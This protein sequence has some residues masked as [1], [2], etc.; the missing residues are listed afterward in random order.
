[1]AD[2]TREADAMDARAIGDV[3]RVSKRAVTKRADKDGWLYGEE[4]VSGGMR[5]LYPVSSLP[6]EVREAVL[7]HRA[8]QAA[9]QAAPAQSEGRA[10]GRKL[11]IAD[12]VD[13]AVQQRLRERGQAAAA[14][15]TGKPRERMDA[16]LELLSRLSQFARARAIGICAAM[17]EFCDAYNSG[18]MDVPVRVRSHTGADLHPTTLRRWRR[19]VKEQGP[20]ALAGGYGNRKGSNGIESTPALRDFVLGV[21]REQPHISA[22]VMHDAIAARLPE[23]LPNRRT[24]ERFL[25]TWKRDNAELFLAVTNPDAWKNKYM[26]AF[27][28]ASE[29]I[30]RANQ[31][32]ML[33]STPADLM[34]V[35]GRHSLVGM[36]DVATRQFRLY[37]SRTSTADAV[38]QILRRGILELGV[39]EA[40]KMDNGRDY[41]SQRVAGVLAGL[42]IEARFSAPFSPWEKPHIERAFRTFS[43]DLLEILPGYGGHNV[44]EAQAIRSRTAF[45]EQLFKKNAEPKIRLTAAELQAFC[46]RWVAEVYTHTAHDGLGGMTPF[47]KAAQLRD[48]VRT[49]SDVRALDLLL[50]AGEIRTVG[51]KG[52]RLD[53]LLYIA[54]ELAEAINQPVLVRRDD[55]DIG[56]AVVYY[57][58]RFLCIAE[59]PEVTGV[60]QREVASE[61]KARKAKLLQ[62]QKAELKALGRKANV[63]GL[64]RDI[65]DSKARDNAALHA[66]PAPN[67]VHI[68]PALEAAGVAA[69]ALEQMEQGTAA[70]AS[71]DDAVKA[72][73][74][75]LVRKEQQAEDEAEARFKWALDLL[76]TPAAARNDIDAARLRN[77]TQTP[78]YETRWMFFE[79]FGA[80][81]FGLADHYNAL[82]SADALFHTKGV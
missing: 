4:R 25:A 66:F 52:L 18:A 60:S 45:S 49:V 8:L 56:R 48:L 50:G 77:Y 24:L 47:Q 26:P 7:R 6:A 37:V 39:P 3:L 65:L 31:V 38:C 61:V 1:M 62:L 27:G 10:L 15:V 73:I 44:A 32:W 46:D 71:H 11:G 40:V 68:T 59:C 34:L 17:D 42:H 76:L 33:D 51:K 2:G 75:T 79:E 21:L 53:N 80:G 55:A 20:A 5:R 72:S 14:G 28:N 36:I 63:P 82:L 41:A 19:L 54:P 35:D 22:K 30:V 69:D 58:D 13:G 12:A 16:K 74:V 64:V 29:G 67:V 43:H 57:Q 23:L 70:K 81:T 78:E 9:A